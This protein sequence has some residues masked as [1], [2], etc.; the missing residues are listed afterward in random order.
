MIGWERPHRAHGL[1]ERASTDSSHLGWLGALLFVVAVGSALACLPAVAIADT[2]AS[3]GST[4]SNASSDAGPPDAGPPHP[5]AASL[6]SSV[7]S[8]SALPD[9]TDGL[10]RPDELDEPEEPGEADEMENSP[11]VSMK[12]SEGLTNGADPEGG[13]GDPEAA[14]VSDDDLDTSEATFGQAQGPTDSAAGGSPAPADTVTA[15]TNPASATPADDGLLDAGAV[16]DSVWLFGNGTA[17]HPDGGIIWGVG[18]SWDA[19]TCLGG[20]VCHGGNGATGGGAG[21]NGGNGGSAGW[22]GHGGAGGMGLPGGDGGNGGNGGSL[23]GNGGN[24]GAGGVALVP[25]GIGGNGGNG[26]GTGRF[27]WLG[28]VGAAG[29]GTDGG[30][31]GQR[32]NA[33]SSLVRINKGSH[34]SLPWRPRFFLTRVSGHATFTSDSVYDLKNDDQY[35]WNKL[36]GITFTPLRPDT[37]AIMVAWRYNVATRMFEIGPY[38]NSDLARIMPTDSEIISVPSGHEFSF[39][40]DY[41]GITLAYADRVVYKPIPANLRP[42]VFTASR[43]N[44]WFGGTS[45]APKTLSYYLTFQ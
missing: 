42:N 23:A 8:A 13:I 17:A 33:G 16:D 26:G 1:G 5:D 29:A 11:A 24:G 18:F 12:P 32:G 44:G 34:F 9:E 2:T 7:R 19:T 38:Y 22:F 37:D 10:D 31:S 39:S 14:A 40:V 41:D 25:G 36:A 3:K 4:V 45:V 28:A 30:T 35:D 6:H 27:S 21:F 43:V 20:R 15:V